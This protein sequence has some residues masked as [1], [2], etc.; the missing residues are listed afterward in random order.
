VELFAAM[1]VWAGVIGGA[2]GFFHRKRTLVLDDLKEQIAV[3]SQRSIDDGDALREQV[4]DL[5][6]SVS[7]LYVRKPDLDQAV[8]GVHSAISEVRRD[9]GAVQN[10]VDQLFQNVEFRK[11]RST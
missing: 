11:S 1:G 8:N 5:A 9:V 10:R 4:Q 3:H 7:S 2:F 6:L